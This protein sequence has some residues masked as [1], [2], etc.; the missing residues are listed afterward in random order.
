[1]KRKQLTIILAI[2]LFV[3]ASVYC[4][5]YITKPTIDEPLYIESDI[6]RFANA[7]DGTD[8]KIRKLPDK[9]FCNIPV[10][11]F[12]FYAIAWC[13]P[14]TWE[15][16]RYS[17]TWRS[18]SNNVEYAHTISAGHEV[19]DWV[20]YKV[21]SNQLVDEDEIRKEALKYIIGNHKL[22]IDMNLY[23]IKQGKITG[24]HACSG[25]ENETCLFISGQ[26]N[27]NPED[28][29]RLSKEKT[30]REEAEAID[31]K[32]LRVADGTF[33]SS[34][35]HAVKYLVNK[36]PEYGA[37]LSSGHFSG[38]GTYVVQS[39]NT[40]TNAYYT[41]HAFDNTSDITEQGKTKWLVTVYP[42]SS[43]D[44]IVYS[45]ITG[46]DSVNVIKKFKF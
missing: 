36:Y 9:T 46:E 21:V 14:Y 12:I 1:M 16:N 13:P 2:I 6:S 31:I 41:I 42:Y 43:D 4:H 11:R 45:I 15:Y 30:Y 5:R 18:K 3:G 33:L 26:Y 32:T 22:A 40:T 27:R 29:S 28:M 24:P 44:Q 23:D 38:G 39:I 37:K 35:K 7:P 34:P 10:V 20:N 8:F 19:Y 25:R 17:W